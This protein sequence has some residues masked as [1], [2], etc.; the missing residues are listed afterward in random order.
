M[1]E[2]GIA[3]LYG[4]H[5]YYTGKKADPPA[6]AGHDNYAQWY[7]MLTLDARCDILPSAF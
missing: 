1:F 6:G 4:W 3:A 5:R 2:N 7:G